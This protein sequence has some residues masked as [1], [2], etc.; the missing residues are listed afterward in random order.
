MLVL[1]W[2]AERGSY[3][4]VLKSKRRTKQVQ[5]KKNHLGCEE[6]RLQLNLNFIC[7]RRDENSCSTADKWDVLLHSH[8]SQVPERVG[9]L[10]GKKVCWKKKSVNAEKF[11]KE[12][13]NLVKK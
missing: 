5:L 4:S 13:D 10:R 3:S 6:K 12:T 9:S 8:L 7:L 11:H 2:W 1:G